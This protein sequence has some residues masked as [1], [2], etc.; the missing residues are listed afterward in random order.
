MQKSNWILFVLIAALAVLIFF[1]PYYGW[2]IR[3]FLAPNFGAQNNAAGDLTLQNQNLKAE[4]AKL[5]NIKS[6]FPDRQPNFIG[7]IVYSRYPLN[8]KNEL[9]LNAGARDGVAVNKAVVVGG[10]LVGRVNRVFDTT[11]LVQTVFDGDFQTAVRIGNS[12]APA[13]AKASADTQ[14]LL[15]GGAMPKLTLVPLAANVSA[16][17]IVYSASPDFPYGLPIGEVGSVSTSSDNLFHEATLNFA[18]D[19]NSVEAV[20]VAK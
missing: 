7:A 10:I 9:L 11:A 12:D 20:L 17:D 3:K 2:E 5:E 13:F 19:I 4:L 6:Q 16:G 18:Y 1:K 15:R 14:A 8:F